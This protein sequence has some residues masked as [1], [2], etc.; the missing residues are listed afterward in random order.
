MSLYNFHHTTSYCI[1]FN[2]LTKLRRTDIHVTFSLSNPRFPDYLS[3]DAVSHLLTKGRRGGK[4]VR[5][6]RSG[7]R[8]PKQ[9][10]E[11]RYVVVGS[12][13][14]KNGQRIGAE[15]RY[16]TNPAW[17]SPNPTLLGKWTFLSFTPLPPFSLLSSPGSTINCIPFL[18]ARGVFNVGANLPLAI[19]F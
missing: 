17:P 18:S 8:A 15:E 14:K 10:K 7:E 9:E 5:V 12:G 11:T 3:R 6:T 13:T 19:C 4:G 2:F 16:S 1:F